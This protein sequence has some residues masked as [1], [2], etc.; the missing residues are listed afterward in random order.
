VVALYCIISYFYP[1]A[2]NIR[3]RR[4]ICFASWTEPSQGNIYNQV[5]I[6]VDRDIK[7][8]EEEFPDKKIRPTLTHLA[9]KALG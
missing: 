3:P 6:R 5:K 2:A 8:L 7:F 4:K 1:G 9:I